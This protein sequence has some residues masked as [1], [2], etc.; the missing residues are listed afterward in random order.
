MYG[1]VMPLKIIT[2]EETG[3]LEIARA[4]GEGGMEGLGREVGKEAGV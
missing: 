1:N 3:A 4:D 2:L